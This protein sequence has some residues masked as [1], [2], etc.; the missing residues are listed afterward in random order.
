VSTGKGGA[1]RALPCSNW[2]QLQK[3]HDAA[4]LGALAARVYN[5][6]GPIPR[7]HGATSSISRGHKKPANFPAC[8]GKIQAE[9]ASFKKNNLCLFVEGRSILAVPIPALFSR[10]HP[11]SLFFFDGFSFFSLFLSFCRE[12]GVDV[13]G[14]KKTR[15]R[16]RA[17]AMTEDKALTCEPYYFFFSIFLFSAPAPWRGF[18]ISSFFLFLQQRGSALLFI[19]FFF[20][21]LRQINPHSIHEQPRRFEDDRS[22]AW[23]Q[24]ANRPSWRSFPH[25]SPCRRESVKP[26]PSTPGRRLHFPRG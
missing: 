23:M 26:A 14:F 19:F 4:A 15:S 22:R 3:L 10:A 8:P 17:P 13:A 1:A 9:A 18:K 16:P 25:A 12:E 11:A 7:A 24:V 5:G 2:A 6:P 21:S 20:F